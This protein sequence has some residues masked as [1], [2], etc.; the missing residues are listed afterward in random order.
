MRTINHL[1]MLV[2]VF[3]A[4]A[5]SFAQNQP[6]KPSEPQAN[7]LECT[8]LLEKANNSFW[9]RTRGTET[10]FK[11]ERE[12]KVVVQRCAELP[13]R[14]QAEAQL[15]VVREE[16]AEHNMAIALFYLERYRATG[17]TFGA[18]SRLRGILE[19]YPEYSKLD[20][21]LSLLGQLNLT[22]D[23]LEEA[24]A[25]YERILK[26]FPASQ[27]VGEALIQLRTIDDMRTHGQPER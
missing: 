2:L 16:L 25:C 17:R 22:E 20:Q 18:V 27:Y 19:R 11:A 21:V 15:K 3:A 4:S 8:E 10:Q 13:G 1:G 9:M 24:A 14:Y 23:K 12:L 7:E 5:V 6:V 26:D